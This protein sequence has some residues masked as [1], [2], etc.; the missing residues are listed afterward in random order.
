MDQQRKKVEKIF[1]EVLRLDGSERR[2]FLDQNCEN[3]VIRQEV[4]SLID[5]H[6]KESILD[7][8]LNTIRDEVLSEKR[9]GRMDGEVI[10]RYKIVKQIASGGMGTVFLAE[11]ADGEYE[12]NVALKLL[13]GNI[14]SKQQIQRFRYERQILA[15]LQN[16]HIARLFDGGVT[17][18]GQPWFVMEYIEGISI[19]DYCDEHNLKVKERIELF[20]DVCNAVQ[21]AHQKLV[22]HR[23]LKPSNILVT[24]QGVV[25]LVDFGIA[26]TIDKEQ[27]TEHSESRKG[28]LPLTPAYASPE[29][30]SMGEMATT[31]DQY[32]LGVILYELL[33][34]FRPYNLDDLT[35]EQIADKICRS[36]PARPSERVG[37]GARNVKGSEDLNKRNMDS[38]HLSRKLKGDL[39]SI[40]LKSLSK[41][42]SKRYNSV[43]QMS[44]DLKRYLDRKPVVAHPA[45]KLYKTVKFLKRHPIESVASAIVFMLILVYL[46]TITRYSA[47]TRAALEQ[48]EVEASKSEQVVD[49]LVGMFEAGDPYENIGGE[50]PVSDLLERGRLNAENLHDQPDVQAH[51]FDAIGRVYVSIGEFEEASKLLQRAADFNEKRGNSNPV[52]LADTY[53]HLAFALHHLAEYRE[54]DKLFDRALSNY[55]NVSNHR[56][57]EYANTLNLAANI[58]TTRGNYS[59]AVEMHR[60]SLEMF[61]E[62]SGSDRLMASAYHGLGDALLYAGLTEEAL[63]NLWISFELFE[64][65]FSPNHPFIAGVHESLSRAYLIDEQYDQAERHLMRSLTIRST[66]LGDGHIETGISRK[67]LA[68]FYKNLERYDEAGEIYQELLNG[69][70]D[71]NPLRRPV[72]QAMADLYT[73]SA[74]YEKAESY[75]RQTADLLREHLH[76]MH[77]RLLSSELNLGKNLMKQGKVDQAEELLIQLQIKIESSGVEADQGFLNEFASVLAELDLHVKQQEVVH[78][79]ERGIQ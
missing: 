35:P 43:E 65:L 61:R 47:Q 63:K 33:T 6:E 46:F 34:G 19:T 41:E 32:Q 56:S 75:Y 16:D 66:V 24:S 13:K 22:V 76:T 7:L 48:V 71:S 77:P 2:E 3:K 72:I 37:G 62:F 23:D 53:Y 74:D 20:L 30:I 54:A 78:G 52:E 29:Q 64:D 57:V 26:K 79:M 36:A 69:M 59:K 8:P 38:R 15:S 11:R 39:D 9:D 55:R 5:A 68:D 70:S 21:Y 40:I 51:I 17:Q 27:G 49:F 14:T 50:V 45:A 67:S 58:E 44:D 10:G 42:P 1:W 12:Q 18:Y 28:L 4:Q 60:E 31:S 73:R 25:K